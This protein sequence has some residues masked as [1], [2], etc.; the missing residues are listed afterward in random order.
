[1]SDGIGM[2][3]HVKLTR[4]PLVYIGEAASLSFLQLIRD[5]VT[6]QIG[7]SQFSHN[8]KRDSMLEMEP[9]A[10]ESSGL[11]TAS[12]NI[13]LEGSL[14]YTRTFEAAVST[15]LTYL[16]FHIGRG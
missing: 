8:E 7:P 9:S 11:G 15:P 2:F 13:D 5:T 12:C 10:A 4:Q 3:V 14:L 16:G 1:M 6:A